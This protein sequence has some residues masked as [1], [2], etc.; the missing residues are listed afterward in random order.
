MINIME[1]WHLGNL[2]TK[3]K[4]ILTKNT[5]TNMYAWTIKAQCVC[6]KK[7][8]KN[9][10]VFPYHCYELDQPT[11][12]KGHYVYNFHKKIHEVYDQPGC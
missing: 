10:Q 8:F 7:W 5:I 9:C 6:E 4:Q 12:Y 11:L 3:D 2:L 1:T